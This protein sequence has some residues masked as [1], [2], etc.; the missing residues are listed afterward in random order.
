M[1]RDLVATY[2]PKRGK[3]FDKWA[4]AD[5]AH[6]SLVFMFSLGLIALVAV[7]FAKVVLERLMELKEIVRIEKIEEGLEEV[8]CRMA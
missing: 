7:K 1:R 8:P 4:R 5:G 3:L 2:N 6:R